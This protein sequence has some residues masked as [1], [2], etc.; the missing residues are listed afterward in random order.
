MVLVTFA[1]PAEAAP[2]IRRL[3]QRSGY[4]S[5]VT[6]KIGGEHVTVT[7][8]GIGLTR[9]EVL[10]G[11]LHQTRPDFVICSGFAGSLRSLVQPGDFVLARNLSDPHLLAHYDDAADA[12]GNFLEV[13]TVATASEKVR[14]AQKK[15]HLAIDM[16]S[17]RLSRLVK[18]RGIPVL[19]ARM[20]SDGLKQEIPG[21]FLGKPL[22]HLRELGAAAVFAAQML[23]VRPRL[24]DRLVALIRDRP[25]PG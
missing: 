2:F 23:Q 14:L 4:G 5:A 11:C 17:V 13:Q 6:G 3:R 15:N 9:P 12:V 7:Y 1:L 24:A 20:I 16:E 18:E 22:R 21:L 10:E 8:V 19:V 25:A